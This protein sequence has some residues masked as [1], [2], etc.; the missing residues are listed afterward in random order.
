MSSIFTKSEMVTKF[1][2]EPVET[3]ASFVVMVVEQN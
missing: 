3:K 1:E 2:L